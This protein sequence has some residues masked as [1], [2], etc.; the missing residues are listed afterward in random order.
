MPQEIAAQIT[1]QS[2][3]E[4][5]PIVS[6]VLGEDA[7][8]KGKVTAVKIGRSLGSATAGIFHVTGLAQTDSRET[9]WSAVVKALGT[10]ENSSPGGEDDPYRELEVYRSGAFAHGCGGMRSAHS[11]GVQ[12]RDGVQ[13]LWLEDLSAAPQPPW[14]PEHFIAVALTSGPVQCVLARGRPAPVGSASAQRGFAEGSR[15]IPLTSRC[16]SVLPN[17]KS[18]N[19]DASLHRLLQ[20]SALVQFWKDCD[21]LLIQAETTS[22]GICHLDCHPKNLFPMLDSGTESYTVG[23]DWVKVGIANHG[24]DIGHSSVLAHDLAGTDATGGSESGDLI[25]HAYLSGLT[26]SGW[27]GNVDGVRLTYLTRLACEAIRHTNFAFNR[28]GRPEKMEIAER[29]VGY[30]FNEIVTRYREAREFYLDCRDEALRLA[31]R[32]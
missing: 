18:M 6:Q 23:I 25:F 16:S 30:P 31:K 21:Q 26:D 12:A 15:R 20:I 8:L 7:I 5:R 17:S 14:K 3:E 32:L 24:I 22:Q 28:T 29:L 2:P 1:G 10:P 4:I 19:H 9:E 13:L 11:Y 27:S